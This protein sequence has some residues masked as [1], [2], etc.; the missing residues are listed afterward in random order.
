VSVRLTF[1]QGE[2]LHLLIADHWDSFALAEPFPG[3]SLRDTAARRCLAQLVERG[4]LQRVAGRSR[5]SPERGSEPIYT[6]TSTARRAYEDWYEQHE[7]EVL[8]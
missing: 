7:H 5:Y 8:P 2:T 4:L 3:Q 6:V 1:V